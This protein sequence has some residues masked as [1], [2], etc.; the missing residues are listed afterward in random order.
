MTTTHRHHGCAAAGGALLTL[1]ITTYATAAGQK[2]WSEG[3]ASWQED[4]TPISP[5]E[6]RYAHAEQLLARLYRP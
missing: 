2:D 5:A 4:L 3:P 1:A 6:W